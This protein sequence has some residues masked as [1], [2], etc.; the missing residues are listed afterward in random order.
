MSLYQNLVECNLGLNF[1]NGKTKKNGH[2]IEPD[3]ETSLTRICK[4][5]DLAECMMQDERYGL[6]CVPCYQKMHPKQTI[7]EK[8]LKL[9]SKKKK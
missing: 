5:L 9:N 6:I 2:K 4:T 7:A 8:Q 3:G 1:S